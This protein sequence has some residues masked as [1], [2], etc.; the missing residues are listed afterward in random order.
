M[1]KYILRRVLFALFSLL[2][3]VMTVMLL[4]YSLIDRRV[5]FMAD[6]VWNKRSNNEQAYYE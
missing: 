2:V 6:D 5:I 4:V 1:G 3:V